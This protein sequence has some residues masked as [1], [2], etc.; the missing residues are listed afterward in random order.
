MGNNSSFFLSSMQLETQQEKVEV[1]KDPNHKMSINDF[2]L[3]SLI[4]KG[5]YGKVMLV[6]SKLDRMIYAIKRN[7][8]IERNILAQ[9]KHPFIV[10]MMNSFQNER[11]L[12]FVLEYCPGGELFQ[13]LQR[14][15]VLTEEQAKFYL[16][17]IVMAIG[18]L[19]EKDIIYRDLK[20]ENVLIDREGFIKLTDFGLSKMDISGHRDAYSLCG[21]PEY[22]APEVLWRIGHGKPAD[23]WA[24]GCLLYEVL[25]GYPPFYAKT[26]EE[27]FHQIQFGS[28]KIPGFVSANAANL[29]QSLL[30]RDPDFRLGSN[31]DVDDLKQHS[32]FSDVD[33]DA[34]LRREIPPPFIPVL[35]SD[36]DLSYFAKEFVEVPVH[37]E[38]ESPFTPRGDSCMKYDGFSFDA[39]EHINGF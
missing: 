33:W 17:Q 10:R 5:T 7:I 12:F 20:P 1:I 8:K 4:G 25:V 28:V 39:N 38:P 29:I 26:R 31:D 6:R 24:V 2:M 19:H 16:A 18:H 13:L 37:N 35:N 36:Q 23:W 27:V 32:W 11:K 21:T 30:K 14:T 3:L 34:M 15:R 22:L 9:M